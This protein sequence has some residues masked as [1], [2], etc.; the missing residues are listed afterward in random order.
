MT[1]V[2]SDKKYCAKCFKL[3]Q[4]ELHRLYDRG[5]VAKARYKRYRNTDKYRT[6]ATNR[7]H[8][9]AENIRKARYYISN[10]IRDGR[11]KRP[12]KC[13]ECGID[14]WGKKRSMIEAHH[15]LGYEKVNW[16]KI[17]WLCTNCHK[18]ADKKG[19]GAL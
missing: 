16:L 10:A 4:R 18:L 3:H 19:G 13:A 17:K 1:N 2:R 12:K 14:D 5:E 15:Y 7:Y 11:L 6:Y 9:Q 8:E